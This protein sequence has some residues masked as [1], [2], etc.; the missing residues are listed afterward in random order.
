MAGL[1][2]ERARLRRLITEHHGV[3]GLRAAIFRALEVDEAESPDDVIAAACA[4]QAFDQMGLR[5]VGEALAGGSA[6]EAGKSGQL[7]AWLAAGLVER[8]ARFD[9]YCSLYL[10]KEEA[11]R[12]RLLTRA[13]ADAV[14][15]ALEVMQ[16]EAQRLA[17]ARGR[18]NR[19]R[20]A[21]ATAG[22]VA[23]GTEILEAY[24]RHKQARALLDYDDLILAVRNLLEGEGAAAWVLF[25]LD[26]GLDHILV[27]EAQD[28][29]PEQWQVIQ[30][31]AEEFFVGAG[32]REMARDGARTVFAVGDAKQSI[33]SFQRADPTSFARMRAHFAGRTENIGQRLR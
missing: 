8:T 11:P 30:S 28:T 33:Y 16:A 7:R 24:E 18:L 20:V 15:G 4:D 1:I 25:K 9:E 31:L 14:T 19:L 21:R 2:R 13:A 32:A 29:N 3:A 23:L 26:G 6:V 5:L 10:T 27:D 12:A 22:L 17:A